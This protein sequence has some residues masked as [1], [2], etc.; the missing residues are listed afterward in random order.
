MEMICPIAMD[1]KGFKVE[2]LKLKDTTRFV[3]QY[4]DGLEDPNELKIYP[5]GSY[6]EGEPYPDDIP[7]PRTSSEYK[8]FSV[9]R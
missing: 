1:I 5:A 4:F 6:G 3:K 8:F 9:L 2:I 7:V